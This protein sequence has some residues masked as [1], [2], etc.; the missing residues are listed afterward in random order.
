MPLNE[1]CAKETDSDGRSFYVVLSRK[2]RDNTSLKHF[3]SALEDI[4]KDY[5]ERVRAAQTG[6]FD[7]KSVSHSFRIC[8]Q[9]NQI[10][11]NGDLIFPLPEADFL[12]KL[13][14]GELDY[15]RGDIF[16]RLNDEMIKTEELLNKSPLP[17]IVRPELR[18]EILDYIYAKI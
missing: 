7:K 16:N 6:N 14:L 5:G 11:L 13:K 2:Y 4:K 12:R 17:E 8:Y 1:F 10:A 18:E 3:L 15:Q 9:L